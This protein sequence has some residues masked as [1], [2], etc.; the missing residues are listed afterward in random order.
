[1][2]A[3]AQ[4]PYGGCTGLFASKLRSNRIVEEP[5]LPAKNDYAICLTG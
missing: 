4:H 5:G 1:L 2:F 3:I